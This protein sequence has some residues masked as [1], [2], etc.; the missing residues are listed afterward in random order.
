[1]ASVAHDHREAAKIL[2]GEE[3]DKLD[4]SD[5]TV[6]AE[7]LNVPGFKEAVLTHLREP[8]IFTSPEP[9]KNGTTGSKFREDESEKLRD[10]DEPGCG[11]TDP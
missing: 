3:S 5:P 9:A 10:L 7:L 6:I 2:K 11:R 4:F 1:M 8:S